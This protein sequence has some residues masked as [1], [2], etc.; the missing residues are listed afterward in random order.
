MENSKNCNGNKV[1]QSC[2]MPLNNPEDFGTEADGS[3][4]KEY[5]GFCYKDGK[6]TMECSMDELIEYCVPL[7]K[8]YFGGEDGA[9]K[10]MQDVFPTL[11]RWS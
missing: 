10:M 1:C 4:S 5:C 8:D 2:A 3:K 7:C 9:R 11:K 6:F